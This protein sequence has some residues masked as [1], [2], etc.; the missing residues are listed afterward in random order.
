MDMD[1]S[2]DGISL[3]NTNKQQTNKQQLVYMGYIYVFVR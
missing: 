1:M 2:K 3:V